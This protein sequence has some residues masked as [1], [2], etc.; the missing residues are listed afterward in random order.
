MNSNFIY[1]VTV[2]FAPK[3]EE[4]ATETFFSKLESMWIAATLEKKDHLGSKE[5]A[6]P[7]KG[8]KKGDF[9]TLTFTADK[10]LKLNEA[11]LYLNREPVVIR[12]LVIKK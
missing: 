11:N 9:W 10:S 3:T 12:Y 2:V 1:E 8:H 6:Y 5:L 4:K 7:I